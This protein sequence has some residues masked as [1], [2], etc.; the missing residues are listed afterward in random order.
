[1]TPPRT[2]CGL[3]GTR[4]L[5]SGRLT[6]TIAVNPLQASL[7]EIVRPRHDHDPGGCHCSADTGMASWYVTT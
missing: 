4:T 2:R 3:K 1:M 6:L 5:V 7:P